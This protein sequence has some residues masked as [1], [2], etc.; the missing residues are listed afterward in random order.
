V[1]LHRE[2][3]T[4]RRRPVA[5]LVALVAGAVTASSLSPR[6]L[7]RQGGPGVTVHE[8]VR[9]T[10]SGAN[11]AWLEGASAQVFDTSLGHGPSCR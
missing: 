8:C 10:A 4:E 1:R 5:A 2:T 9:P 3:G 6:A 11:E 7:A